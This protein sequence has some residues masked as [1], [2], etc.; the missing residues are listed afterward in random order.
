MK[1]G[2]LTYHRSHNYGALLQA[3]ALRKVLS[4]L[5]HDASFV[6]YWPDYHKKMYNLFDWS[7]LKYCSLPG[8]VKVSLIYL[9][10]SPLKY[11]RRRKFLNFIER[12]ISPYCRPVS[13][14][15]DTIVCGSDQIWRKQ[16]GLGGKYNPIYFG[17][18]STDAD[19]YISYA[20]SMGSTD[21]SEENLNQIRTML[22]GMKAISVRENQ[23]KSLLDSAGINNV[24]TVLDPTLLLTRQQWEDITGQQNQS[25]KNKYLL[26]YELKRE[27][28]FNRKA[29]YD[30]ARRRNLDVKILRGTVGLESLEHNATSLADPFDMVRMIANADTV[31]TSSY[32]GLVFSI[33]FGK[34]VVASFANDSSRAANLLQS[35]G[36]PERLIPVGDRNLDFEAMDYLKVD[37]KLTALRNASLQWLKNA[38]SSCSN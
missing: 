23:L 17:A 29:V 13:D 37:A 16:P 36:Y 38:L 1:T 11:L 25:A 10:F 30:Y 8:K 22:L 33:I 4:D 15:F 2:I 19:R 26:V 12:H 3:L 7:V 31:F 35:I 24:E 18:G 27:T 32:H 9:A 6:D 5:G 34:Q 20:A 28:T 14:H 21:V